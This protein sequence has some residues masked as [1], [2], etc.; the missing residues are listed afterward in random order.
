MTHITDIFSRKT[1]RNLLLIMVLTLLFSLSIN[2]SSASIT[3]GSHCDDLSIGPDL[4]FCLGVAICN[5]PLDVDRFVFI[6]LSNNTVCPNFSP[7]VV[8]TVTSDARVGDPG[9]VGTARSTAVGGAIVAFGVAFSNCNGTRGDAVNYFPANC[10]S[11]ILPPLDPIY[12]FTE[13]CA[14]QACDTS[15]YWWSFAG[16]YCTPSPTVQTECE[17]GGWFWNPISDYCQQD[18]PP[19]CGLEPSVCDPGSWSFEWCDCVPYTS[20][21]VVDIKG[22]GFD[23][24]DGAGGTTF[25]LNNVG[26]KEKLAWTRSKSDDAWLVL[27]RDGNGTIDDGTELFGDV[28]PQSEPAAT[29]KKNGFRALAEYDQIAKGGNADGQIDAN[30]SVFSKLRLWQD[31]N[32]NGLT[33]PGELHTLP[34]LNLAGLELDY[35][36]S[37]KTDK[38][39]NEFA[40]RAKVKDAKGQDLGR[41]AWDVYLVRPK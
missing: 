38:N 27:D 8:N 7:P 31:V 2:R 15:G 29:E 22:N 11:G 34:E 39:G 5:P 21:I 41:W 24:T 4:A 33:D 19:P 18:A 16:T 12:C 32:H 36:L 14:Q 28:T 37:K 10:A 30:D 6:W 40:F 23:L 1:L 17:G 9:I 26:G 20:P 25:N 13:G 3:I 35:K